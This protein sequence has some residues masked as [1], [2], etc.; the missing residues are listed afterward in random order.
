LPA[1]RL[2]TYTRGRQTGPRIIITERECPNHCHTSTQIIDASSLNLNF[3]SASSPY[4]RSE[5][6]VL[7]SPTPPPSKASLTTHT[8]KSSKEPNKFESSKS[9]VAHFIL[10]GTGAILDLILAIEVVDARLKAV[11]GHELENS[12]KLKALPATRRQI[13]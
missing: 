4:S 10:R 2:A 5:V 1:A 7:Q 11:S 12:H 8:R 9:H 6:E 3:H 13:P